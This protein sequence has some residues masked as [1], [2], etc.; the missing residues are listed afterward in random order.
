MSLF[1]LLRAYQS[2]NPGPRQ[3]FRF[4]NKASLYG[5]ELLAPRPTPS[6]R[7]TP[8]R[9]SSNAYSLYSQLP[10]ISEGVPPSATWGR[11][12]PVDPL[13][14]GTLFYLQLILS[15]GSYCGVR[16]WPQQRFTLGKVDRH[17]F[18]TCT[19]YI[20]VQN[21]LGWRGD[22]LFQCEIT[23][24]LYV[25]LCVVRDVHRLDLKLATKEK[26]IKWQPL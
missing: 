14:T 20:P 25:V 1:S 12:M 23:Q 13:I 19:C 4:R 26:P 24:L 2:G 11:A 5:E 17:L 16:G 3:V 18:K 21:T 9:L 7:T 6:W 22:V 10:S 8:C 15:T